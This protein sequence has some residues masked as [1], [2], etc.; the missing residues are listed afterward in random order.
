MGNYKDK[1]LE[2]GYEPVG[3]MVDWLGNDYR[4]QQMLIKD[5]DIK[6]VNER[7]EEI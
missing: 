3:E 6:F 2:E 5:D 4:K 1:L 7:G